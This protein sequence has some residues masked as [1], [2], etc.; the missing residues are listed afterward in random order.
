MAFFQLGRKIDLAKEYSLEE[1]PIFSLL[2]PFEQKLIE[3]KA[4][5]IECKR[6]DVV[7]HE[8]TPADAF[9][10]VISGRFRLYNHTKDSTEGHT[11]TYFYRGDHFGETSLLTGKMHSANVEAKRNG[12]ILRIE[13]ED[14][15][16]FIN[17]IPKLSLHLS[18]SQI[19][20]A[21]V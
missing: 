6:G 13:K 7:Y 12:L 10:V 4:R 20:R 8:N 15:L 9:Y 19:G 11:L 21:H 16:K 14:F 5:L 3:K 18:R 1:I 17:E 2:N